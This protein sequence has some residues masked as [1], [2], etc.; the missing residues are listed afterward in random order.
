[1]SWR[2]SM[3]QYYGFNTGEVLIGILRLLKDKGILQ[4]S[5]ILDVLWDAKDPL[6]PWTKQ[7]IKDLIKL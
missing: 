1:M 7:E 3:D 4:E 5:E 2:E 6:F